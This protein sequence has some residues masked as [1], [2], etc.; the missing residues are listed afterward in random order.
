[1][2]HTLMVHNLNQQTDSTDF[3]GGYKPIDLRAACV[4]VMNEFGQVFPKTFSRSEHVSFLNNIKSAFDTRN[5]KLLVA[6]FHQA[7]KMA[8]EK[9]NPS[10]N[11]SIESVLSWSSKYCLSFRII[12]RKT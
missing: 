10:I 6:C 7:L 8:E 2:G 4:P 11:S 3:L 9:F 5:W 12:K 1:M